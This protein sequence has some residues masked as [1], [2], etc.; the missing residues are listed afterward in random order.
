MKNIITFGT[1]DVF[2]VGHLNI[3]RRAKALGDRLIVG[4]SSDALNVKKKGRF[5]IY[6]EGDRLSIIQGIRYVDDV[7]LEE[8]LELKAEYIKEHSAGV[9][10]MGDDWEG[11]FD[12]LS[13]IVKVVYLARTPSV[14]TTSVIEII[15]DTRAAC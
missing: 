9:L 14:S 2:H 4:V 10:V 12:Y 6:S 11:R 13:D 8:S 15:Q 7:F 3:L 5:P 1:F